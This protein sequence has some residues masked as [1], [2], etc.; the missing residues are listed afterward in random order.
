MSDFGQK[1]LAGHELMKSMAKDRKPLEPV[2]W[3]KPD[4]AHELHIEYEDNK[5]GETQLIC[6]MCKCEFES[7]WKSFSQAIS[8][9][10]NHTDNLWEVAK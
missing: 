5:P 8:E 2:E 1:T 7:E 6:C 3:K 4:L 10:E 9:Y